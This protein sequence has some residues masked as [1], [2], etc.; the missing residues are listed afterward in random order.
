MPRRQEKGSVGNGASS[1]PLLKQQ[2]K[3]RKPIKVPL[4]DLEARSCHP[5]AGSRPNNRSRC[6]PRKT[7]GLG[8]YLPGST[9]L[10]TAPSG[11]DIGL[12][13]KW[14]HLILSF[15]RWQKQQVGGNLS[16]HPPP[17][18]SMVLD[19]LWYIPAIIWSLFSTMEPLK[20]PWTIP[21]PLSPTWEHLQAAN[22]RMWIWQT[23]TSLGPTAKRVIDKVPCAKV[24]RNHQQGPTR[25]KN[26]KGRGSRMALGA[27][28]HLFCLSL[29]CNS[30]S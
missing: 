14:F 3:H 27:G 28:T 22:T 10:N 23:E 5:R 30:P 17:F 9:V 15:E 4:E 8:P 2:E 21:V 13:Q 25:G 6:F 1:R 26:M 11:V 29:S 7:S 18:E 12:F 19:E 16:F 20:M 24:S